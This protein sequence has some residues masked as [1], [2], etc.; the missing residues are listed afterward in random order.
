VSACPTGALMDNPDRPML[1]FSED[2]CV[3]CGLCKA[4]CPEKVIT[5]R[6]QI[7]FRAATASARVLNEEEP[8]CCIRCGK[9]FGV[10]STIERVAAKLEARHWM[11]KGS[12]Q[13][14]EV[15][16]MCDDCRVATVHEQD[17]D[18][19]GPPRPKVRTSEDYLREREK[20]GES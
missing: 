11:F 2:A 19:Y 20:K 14:L 5:L 13:R 18:P 17:F 12:A 16:K 15:L 10:K 9:P 3:Q 6:P 4:T 7:D 1:R 8:F